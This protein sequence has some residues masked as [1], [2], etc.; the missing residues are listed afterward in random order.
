M[1]QNRRLLHSQAN[2]WQQLSPTGYIPILSSFTA[3]WSDA[4]DAFYV[5]GGYISDQDRGILDGSG[6]QNDLYVYH[7]QAGVV[8]EAGRKLQTPMSTSVFEE[9]L[10]NEVV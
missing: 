9:M 5:F 4:A 6:D 2:T 8:G 7:S 10:G 1:A 3:V